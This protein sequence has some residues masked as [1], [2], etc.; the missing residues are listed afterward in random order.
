MHQVI[1][2]PMEAAERPQVADS[3]K[4]RRKKTEEQ[5]V[6][7]ETAAVI[8][9]RGAGWSTWQ[10]PT[11]RSAPPRSARTATPRTPRQLL[12]PTPAVTQEI[13]S[14]TAVEAAVAGNEELADLALSGVEEVPVPVVEERPAQVA[15]QEGS[16]PEEEGAASLDVGDVKIELGAEEPSKTGAE[17]G[18]N[19][20]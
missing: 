17:E 16:S 10:P 12:P 7:E 1:D 4:K 15:W 5:A 3:K 9:D 14:S 19:P 13:N 6:D 11:P 2:L 8:P 18:S 20:T